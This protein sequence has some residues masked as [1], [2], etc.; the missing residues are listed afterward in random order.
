MHIPFDPEQVDWASFVSASNNDVGVQFGSGY[1]TF[2]GFYQ[3]GGGGYTYFE[4]SPYQ[5]G[6]GLGSVF[7]SLFRALVPLGKRAASAVGQ[8]GLATAARVLNNA[9]NPVGDS[10]I[11]WRENLA[12][13]TRTGV[14]NL[15]GR[16]A[17][18]LKKGG[19]QTGGS[20]PPTKRKRAPKAY[21]N[22][23]GLGDDH[24]NHLYSLKGPSK[25]KK[26]RFDS[27]GT[28]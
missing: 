12:K 22:A 7:R 1:T 11:D 23:L 20:G 24:H 28:Y 21:I 13:E 5:R 15:L 4:G 18:H 26:P 27:L 14:G 10:P 19:P 2:E 8:E 3:R 25:A 9:V 16:A 6:A 17:D